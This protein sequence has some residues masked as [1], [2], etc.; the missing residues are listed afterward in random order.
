MGIYVRE[1]RDP[2]QSMELRGID[3]TQLARHGMVVRDCNPN[4]EEP[5]MGESQVQGQ[6]GL[7][8]ET[9]SQTLP[10]KTAHSWRDGTKDRP[11]TH[12]LIISAPI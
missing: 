2:R 12:S 6:L 10:P 11:A 5:E 9:L 1:Q 7:H 4:S 3:C 8:S